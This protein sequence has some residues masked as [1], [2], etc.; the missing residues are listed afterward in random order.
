MSQIRKDILEKSGKQDEYMSKEEFADFLTYLT[1]QIDS[2]K[3]HD[4]I[5]NYLQGQPQLV[6][7]AKFSN[8]NLII[9]IVSW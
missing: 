7:W 6:I 5:V 3:V 9:F 8:T 4:Q 2:T 1:D